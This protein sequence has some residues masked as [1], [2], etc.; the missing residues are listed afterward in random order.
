MALAD[1]L[2]GVL[3][4]EVV[5]IG[6]G[7]VLLGFGLRRARALTKQV[8]GI[9][10]QTGK[11]AEI[12]AEAAAHMELSA[13]AAWSASVACHAIARD[14]RPLHEDPAVPSAGFSGRVPGA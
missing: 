14:L 12:V 11:L 10:W 8:A 7:L 4:V 3:A 2:V 5:L 6:I 13:Q 1:A 9:N